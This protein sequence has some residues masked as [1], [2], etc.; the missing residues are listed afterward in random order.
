MTVIRG[1]KPFSKIKFVKA[2]EMRRTISRIQIE[3]PFYREGYLFFLLYIVRSGY[4][5]EAKINL[6]Q[7]I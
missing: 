3:M 6:H 5:C 7:L 2:S 1:E 4:E